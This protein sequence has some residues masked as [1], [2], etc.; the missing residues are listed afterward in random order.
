MKKKNN[1]IRINYIG[2][3]CIVLLF[4][5]IIFR[6]I[7]VSSLNKV[8]GTDIKKFAENRNTTTKT[9]TASR[10]SIYSVNNE[11]LAQD[12]NSY[13]VIAYLSPSRTTNKK[14]PKHVVDKEYTAN[15]LSEYLGMTPETILGLLNYNTYQVELGP[16]G[17]NISENLKQ[18][19]AALDLPGIDFE[20]SSKRYY[21]FGDFASYIIGY[22]KKDDKGNL[23]GELGVEAFYNDELTG[24]NGYTTYQQDAYG[25]QIPD[26]PVITS[27]AKKGEDIYLTIDSNVQM[28]LE[29]AL[30]EMGNKAKFEWATVTVADATTGAILGSASTPSY[31]PN[32]LNITNYNNPLVSYSYEPGS[33]MKI[34]SFMAA[35]EEGLYHG[36]EIY[37][38][39]VMNIGDDKVTDWNKYGWGNIS[40]D[41]GFTYSSNV[42]A[43]KLG[44]AVGKEKLVKYYENF[45]F[46]SKTGIE[47][48]NEY[49]GEIDPIYKIEV[50]NASFGQG[51]TTTPIQNIEALTSLA[52]EGTVLKPYIV[53]KIVNQDTGKTVYKGK[54]QE[55]RKVVSKETVDTMLKLMYL[56]VNSDD[57]ATTG[58]IYKTSSTTL[59]GKTGTAQ[60]ASASG[61][62]I[63]DGTSNIRSF[64]GLFPYEKPKFIIY[65]SVQRLVGSSNVMGDAVKSIVESISK[66]KNLSE[67]V[68]QED[69]TQIIKVNNYINKNI[70]LSAQELKNLGLNVVTIG[71][72][73]RII[74]QYPAKGNKITKGSKIYVLTNSEK[75]YMPSMI[76]WTSSDAKNF[77]NLTKLKCKIE[78][79]GTVNNQSIKAGDEIN[80]EVEIHIT[81][82]RKKGETDKEEKL[83]DKTKQEENKQT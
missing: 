66:Y 75:I 79:Y 50:A 12:V 2:I 33:T 60:I 57:Q 22:A 78:G 20:S 3:I 41:V 65:I 42:A 21:P 54:K 27:K 18:K 13:T 68:V 7:L 19:I 70:D 76:G 63:L 32:K 56:T 46:G 6:L 59:V 36:D 64:S 1:T 53:S 62:Y 69:T 24:K 40:Y 55:L 49:S 83:D 51:I 43:A 9:L 80:P 61:G 72:G 48:A 37:Y 17:R 71:V 81:L 74:D 31:D 30:N 39:G 8:D 14:Y 82:A 28:Y 4:G 26:T 5:V 67:L 58:Q 16:G 47:M 35:M 44:L 23:V 73:D 52:N 38:S 25:Y 45:G 10:G 77:C 34:F 11:V 15:A 29:N